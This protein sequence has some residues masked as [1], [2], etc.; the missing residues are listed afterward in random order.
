MPG[1][2]NAH[3]A[4]AGGPF[5]AQRA[6]LQGFQLVHLHPE[7]YPAVLPGA[8]TQ[9]VS[10]YALTYNAEAW[11]RALPFLD[12]LEGLDEMPPLYSRERVTLQTVAGELE[13]WV[14][15]YAR[16]ERLKQPGAVGVPS[17]NWLDIEGR[18]KHGPNE[19]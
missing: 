12:H 3:V 6:T 2:R 11:A 7:G 14:Y 13:A 10:G 19:R 16:P 17:G 1:E 15:V 4:E 8:A 5:T 9:Q 18:Q